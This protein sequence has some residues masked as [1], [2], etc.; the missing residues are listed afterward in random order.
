MGADAADNAELVRR[1]RQELLEGRAVTAVDRYFAD[2]FVSHNTPPG[3][4]GG[5]EGVKRFFEMFRDAL[6]DLEVSIDE[7]VAEGDRVA[8][9]TTMR[10]T[11]R[12]ELMGL[13]ATGRRVAVTGVDIVRLEDGKIV[14]HRGL[15]DTVGLMR[16][17]AGG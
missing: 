1:M 16:Q 14:E 5:V 3:L 4:P 10:G 17:L 11:H 9:A 7:I 13:A 8:V 15:T 6:S 2:G 12:G